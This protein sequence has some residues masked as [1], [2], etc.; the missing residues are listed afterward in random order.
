MK[1]LSNETEIARIKVTLK[2]TLWI[3]SMYNKYRPCLCFRTRIPSVCCLL[4]ELR[5][6][7]PPCHWCHCA[8]TIVSGDSELMIVTAETVIS[9][10]PGHTQ[11]C[12]VSL[13]KPSLVLSQSSVIQLRLRPGL[14]A[15]L[16]QRL[17]AGAAIAGLS[18]RLQLWQLPAAWRVKQLAV[19]AV[20][21]LGGWCQAVRQ[22]CQ[23]S[24]GQDFTSRTLLSHHYHHNHH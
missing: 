21:S 3:Q 6:P 13:D 12:S 7:G 2:A 1:S 8:L 16:R 14:P 10:G 18:A 17:E 22:G 20:M 5:L 9:A 4:T 24:Q 15:P 11:L 23:G 19:T